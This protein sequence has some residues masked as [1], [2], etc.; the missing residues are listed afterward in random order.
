MKV[1]QI[2][3]INMKEFKSTFGQGSNT[4]C[5][6]VSSTSSALT[7]D[8]RWCIFTTHKQEVTDTQSIILWKKIRRHFMN[9]G[10]EIQL[11]HQHNSSVHVG[12]RICMP[13]SNI[14][15]N[16]QCLFMIFSYQAPD[17]SAVSDPVGV[18]LYLVRCI[19]Y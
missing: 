9:P 8:D 14:H 18:K 19:M 3:Q 13:C 10:R 11:F 15:C 7:D 17:P 12:V 16:I 2:L 5:P 1:L 4:T 6:D